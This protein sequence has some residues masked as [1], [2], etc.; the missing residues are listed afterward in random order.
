MKCYVHPDMDAVGTCSNCGKF[1]CSNCA[2][3]YKGKVTCKSCVEKL[4]SAPPEAAPVTA[5]AAPA[6]G[7]KEPIFAIILSFLF[8]GLGQ[9]YNGQ[10]KKGVILIIV[11][12]VLWIGVFVVYL[13]GS[14][15]TMG[16]G[17]LCC[18]PIFIVP[19]IEWLYGMY[20]GYSVANKINRGEYTKDWLS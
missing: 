2:V 5:A 10:V 15:V 9:V 18:M 11:Y 6:P 12:I 4:A 17:A 3:D 1:V 19:L 14:L 7:R 20:D 8:P 16:V 13:G